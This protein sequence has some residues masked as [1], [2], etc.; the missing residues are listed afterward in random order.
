LPL[1]MTRPL[2]PTPADFQR[3]VGVLR[4]KIETLAA[5]SGLSDV[6]RSDLQWSLAAMPPSLRDPVRRMLNGIEIRS[7]HLEPTMAFATRYILVLAQD[8]WEA[9]PRPVRH[10]PPAREPLRTIN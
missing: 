5:R 4:R 6:D 8:I 9:N 3:C 1:P 7:R 2:R 10:A